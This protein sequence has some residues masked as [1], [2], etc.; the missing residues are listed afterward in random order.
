MLLLKDNTQL[1]RGGVPEWPKGSD[2]KSD[3]SAFGGSNPPPSTM[4]FLQEVRVP[5]GN[6]RYI[7]A[8]AGVVQRLEPQPSKLMMWVRFPSPAPFKWLRGPYSS[9]VEHFLGK[10]EVSGSSPDMGSIL[11]LFIY[12]VILVFHILDDFRRPAGVQGKI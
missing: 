9:A 12:R 2:C 3:G 5:D 6:L 7:R 1:A 10:E 11:G 8:L 4:F